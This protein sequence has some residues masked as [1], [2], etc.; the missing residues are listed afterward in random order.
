MALFDKMRAKRAAGQGIFGKQGGFGSGQGYFGRDRGLTRSSRPV[1]A[2]GF[3]SGRGWLS[4]IGKGGSGF[5]GRF[6]QGSG[7]LARL[8]NPRKFDLDGV[9]TYGQSFKHYTDP[10]AIKNIDEILDAQQQE[11]W[12]EDYENLLLG[13]GEDVLGGGEL[14]GGSNPY[15][16]FNPLDAA[17]QNESGAKPG[18]PTQMFT[19]DNLGYDPYL[20]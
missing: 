19:G 1:N 4:R 14:S 7:N 6:G 10:K 15:A 9:E 5:M 18:E 13:E 16:T 20:K 3:G 8:F 12:I 17:W 2:G 11:G